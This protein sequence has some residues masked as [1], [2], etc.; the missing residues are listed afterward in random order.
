MDYAQ[1]VARIIFEQLG[2]AQIAMAT[3]STGFGLIKKDGMM[4]L[5][6]NVGHNAMGVTACKIYLTAMDDYLVEFYKNGVRSSLV[7]SIYCEN[8]PEVF[9]IAT[10][11]HTFSPERIQK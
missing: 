1:G 5:G 10:G 9:H 2:G 8:I 7:R 6:F 4:G 11:I 3:G